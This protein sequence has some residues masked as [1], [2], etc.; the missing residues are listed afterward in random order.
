VQFRDNYGVAD[1]DI[2]DDIYIPAKTFLPGLWDKLVKDAKQ[3]GITMNED[4]KS[5]NS[6][7][8]KLND[9]VRSQLVTGQIL[10]VHGREWKPK[11]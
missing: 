5:C 6:L 10:G 8:K 3:R 4:S 11:I 9:K 2:G 1:T 7:S